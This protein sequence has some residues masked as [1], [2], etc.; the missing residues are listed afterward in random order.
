MRKE[1]RVLGAMS[2][3]DRERKAG[4]AIFTLN[5]RTET[6]FFVGGH[7]VGHFSQKVVSRVD[8]ASRPKSMGEAPAHPWLKW[9]Q[10]S[11]IESSWM[12]GQILNRKQNNCRLCRLS[13]ITARCSSLGVFF[14]VKIS[15]FCAWRHVRSN[16]VLYYKKKWPNWH[17][18]EGYFTPLFSLFHS[19]TP[20]MCTNDKAHLFQIKK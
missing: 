7:T 20:P 2:Q 12:D 18:R 19:P 10:G 15:F 8:R 5:L 14:P 16:I 9:S 1:A 6:F 11:T 17:W 4:A 3:K 13:K